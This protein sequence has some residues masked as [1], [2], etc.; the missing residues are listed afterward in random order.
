MELSNFTKVKTVNPSRF[1]NQPYDIRIEKDGRFLFTPQAFRTLGMEENSLSQYNDG[2]NRQIALVTM[3]GDKG[4]FA[5]QIKGKKKGR[6]HKNETLLANLREFGVTG[7]YLSLTFIGEDSGS[8][9]YLI[10]EFTGDIDASNDES[11]DEEENQ[12]QAGE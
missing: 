5:R 6:A 12:D 8:K 4:E 7:N 3:P 2:E 9:Y 1:G 11:A 10:S